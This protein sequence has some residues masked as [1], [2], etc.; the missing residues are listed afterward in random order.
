M[1]ALGTGLKVPGALVN[2]VSGYTDRVIDRHGPVRIQRGNGSV[3]TSKNNR[4]IVDGRL[5]D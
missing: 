4:L 1:I 3:L 2:F 5:V